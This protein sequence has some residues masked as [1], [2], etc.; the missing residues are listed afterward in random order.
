MVISQASLSFYKANKLKKLLRVVPRSKRHVIKLWGHAS[1]TDGYVPVYE[2]AEL[3][4][5]ETF[6][7]HWEGGWVGQAGNV[8]EGKNLSDGNGTRDY[9]PISSHFIEGSMPVNRNV[10]SSEKSRTVLEVL[11]EFHC[12]L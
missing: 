1:E 9:Q 5:G 3:S 2:S 8:V 4:Q 12:G 6:G 7:F 11:I 10:H